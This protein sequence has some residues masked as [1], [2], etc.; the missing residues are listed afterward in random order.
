MDFLSVAA[1]TPTRRAS[2]PIRFRSIGSDIGSGSAPSRNRPLVLPRAF[3][4]RSPKLVARNLL[5]KLLVRNRQGKRLIGRI[6][7]V[8][9]YLGEADPASHAFGGRSHTTP[10][11]SDPQAIWM[12]I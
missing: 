5:G 10:C 2:G 3:Y 4:E 11:C 12:Y 9:A 6:S 8:E 7:E 1:R